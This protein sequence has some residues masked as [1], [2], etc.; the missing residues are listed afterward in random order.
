MQKKR[1][2]T[3]L[4]AFL[5]IIGVLLFIWF[6]Y[7]SVQRHDRYR[8]R[9]LIKDVYQNKVI[10]KQFDTGLGVQGF[11]LAPSD[12]QAEKQVVYTT[13]H[14]TAIID[15]ILKHPD[16]KTGTMVNMNQAYQNFYQQD[17]KADKLLEKAGKSH[18]IQQGQSNAPHQLYAVIDPNCRYCHAFFNAIQPSIEKG[19][20]AVRWILVGAV[21]K[22]SQA[23][24]AAILSS[25]DPLDALKENETQFHEESG[26]I[27]PV[28]NV[29][30]KQKN[31]LNDNLQMVSEVGSVP[32]VVFLNTQ[33]FARFMKGHQLPLASPDMS[34][35]QI[36][37]MVSGFIA[38]VGQTWTK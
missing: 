20:V 24:A 4:I 30:E 8:A 26:G 14:G 21:T 6:Y 16:P 17:A 22:T 11:I 37:D 35:N 3:G 23:K 36:K 25:N 1:F 18:Y 31:Q 7:A 13:K 9:H 12:D 19:D 32:F 15:G 33:G 28:A 38:V 29:A 27:D 34:D 5:I 2:S 10:E